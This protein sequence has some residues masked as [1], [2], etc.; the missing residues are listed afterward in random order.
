MLKFTIYGEPFGKLNLRPRMMGKHA[1]VYPPK[2]NENY[3]KE[4]CNTLD[5][6]EA[7]KTFSKENPMFPK[8]TP[9]NV[10]IVA[11]F[12]I[13]ESHFKFYKKENVSRYDAKG[14]EMLDGVIRPT[15]K[16]DLDNISKIVCDG[17]TK[18]G[19]VWH[20]DCQVVSETMTKYY[21][22][23]PRVE[24]EIEEVEG[25]KIDGEIS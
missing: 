6:L 23:E 15:K 24:V 10:K 2:E 21:A 1:S 8:E 13:P 7:L 3:M 18:Y 12:K 14:Q 20:D 5:S 4:V 19:K 9:V 17:I 22:D 11:Y 25:A 16:P